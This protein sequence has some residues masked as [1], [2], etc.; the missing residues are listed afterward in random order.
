MLLCY[1]FFD[2]HFIVYDDD[3][4]LTEVTDIHCYCC[5]DKEKKKCKQGSQGE[6]T[7][8]DI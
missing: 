6:K 3:V 7:A 8:N 4:Y 1:M 2:Q 5:K